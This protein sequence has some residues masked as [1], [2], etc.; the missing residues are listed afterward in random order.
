MVARTKSPKWKYLLAG[1]ITLVALVVS[2]IFY[3][4][5]ASA[6]PLPQTAQDPLFKTKAQI[7]AECVELHKHDADKGIYYVQDPC[8]DGQIQY[9]YEHQ[10]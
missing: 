1:L 5:H 8:N 9:E 6:P 7:K 10:K 3:Y 2:A 4:G